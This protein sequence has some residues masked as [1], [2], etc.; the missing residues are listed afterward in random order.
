LT[1][2]KQGDGWA[3][4]IQYIK[5]KLTALIKLKLKLLFASWIQRNTVQYTVALAQLAI[6]CLPSKMNIRV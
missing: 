4:I 2:G 3:N 6:V 5:T 1:Q